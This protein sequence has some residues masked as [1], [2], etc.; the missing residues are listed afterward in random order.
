[1]IY[2]TIEEVTFFINQRII[3]SYHKD[4]ERPHTS[5][6]STGRQFGSGS[7]TKIFSA[8]SLAYTDLTFKIKDLFL[9]CSKSITTH[10][11]L[12]TEL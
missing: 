9:T 12:A 2:N 7:N 3:E 1:M 5:L 11:Y 4:T 8:F 10:L 6:E